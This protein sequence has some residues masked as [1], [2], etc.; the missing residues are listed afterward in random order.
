V[1]TVPLSSVVG[2]NASTSH[3]FDDPAVDRLLPSAVPPARHRPSWK[4][5]AQ[6]PSPHPGRLGNGWDVAF[7]RLAAMTGRAQDLHVVGVVATAQR[8]RDDVIDLPPCAGRE[9][10]AAALAAA[11]RGEEEFEA[12][13]G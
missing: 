11:A 1:I 5:G 10:P 6:V 9:R 12:L 13:A 8:E 2:S 7:A 3:S 4:A